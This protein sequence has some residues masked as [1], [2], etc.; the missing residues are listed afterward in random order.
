MSSY[1]IIEDEDGIAEGQARFIVF[2]VGGGGGNAVQNMVQQDIK[3]VTFVTAN[4]DRQALDKIDVPNKYQLGAQTNRGLGAGGNPEVGREAAESDEAEIKNI[5]QGHDMVFITAGMGGGTGTGAAPVV[6]RIAKEMGILTVAVV[7]TPFAFEGMPRAKS[8]KDGIEQLSAYVDSI[9]VIP[10]QKLN[11]VYRNLSM[12]DAFRKADDILLNGVNGLVQTIRRAGY[13]N[14]DFNDIRTA[15]S[16]KGHAMMGIGRASGDDRAVQATEKAIRSPLLD[17]V[18]LENAKGL[19]VNISASEIMTSEP[20]EIGSVLE[21]IIDLNEGRIFY[22]MVED[23]S[24]GDDIEITVIAT[25]LTV[26]ERP[27]VVQRPAGSPAPQINVQP[28]QQVPQYQNQ[29][30]PVYQEEQPRMTTK[31]SVD[32]YLN[33]QKSTTVADYLKTRQS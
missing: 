33:G 24:L 27:R 30:T 3:G 28:N 20:D 6:A 26:D 29:H 12:R 32:S 18:R 11:Q 23:P 16:A 19:L 1:S 21:S 9:I 7:T 22:G 2:G 10:N 14:I 31:S 15:M 17:D 8:A 13:M 5:L 4:T 25:G